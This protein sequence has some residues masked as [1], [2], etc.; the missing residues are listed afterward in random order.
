MN[1]YIPT[2]GRTDRQT[3]WD[4][5][6]EALRSRAYL[7]CPPEEVHAH[8]LAGRAAIPCPVEGI[9]RKRQWII[10]QFKN[11]QYLC[12][13]DDDLIF[14]KRKDASAWNLAR[15]TP[16]EV[17]D[18]FI[19][20]RSLVREFPQVGVSPRQGNNRFYP[21]NLVTCNRVTNFHCYDLDVIHSLGIKF[22][23]PLFPDTFT[24][25]DF[26]VTLSLLEAGFQNAIITDFA[27]DQHGSN[28]KGGCSLYRNADTQALSATLLARRH[29][30]LV[31]V[32]QKETKGGWAGVANAT[33]GGTR[34]DV[35]I[36]WKKAFEQGAE[37]RAA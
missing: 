34:T 24:M 12:M 1:I 8:N 36:S 18:L 35:V 5:L 22:H 2:R 6:P 25:E 15:C 33:G 31:R 9:I 16:T 10:D 17:E 19:V 30:G 11:D 32:T 13:L 28:S 14:L 29:P 4:E 26:H 27:W 37:R 21:E 7:V 23:D 20:A 3:T